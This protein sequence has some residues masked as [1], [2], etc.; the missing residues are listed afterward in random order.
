VDTLIISKLKNGGGGW[1]AFYGLMLSPSVVEV[2]STIFTA[3]ATLSMDLKLLRLT[4]A[5]LISIPC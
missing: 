3:A 4:I 1:G 2:G 5:H